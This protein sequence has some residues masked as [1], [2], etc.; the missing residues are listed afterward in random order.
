MIKN[1]GMN[2]ADIS[3]EECSII[4]TTALATCFGILLYDEE[5]KIAIVGHATSTW[6]PT[7]LKMLNLIDDEIH[8]FKYLVIPG[9]DSK[10]RD[11]Y[12]TKNKI[13]RF[14]KI[15]N[16]EKVSFVPYDKEYEPYIVLDEKT[17]SYE[18]LFDAQTGK[19][20]LET[21]KLCYNLKGGFNGN[22]TYQ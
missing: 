2:E 3:S 5:N 22:N 8:I 7:V 11:F 14:F 9:Y 10:Q 16:T 6:I 15:F 1:V 12:N 13:N 17:M 4:G 20:V 19:F 21:E 18:F